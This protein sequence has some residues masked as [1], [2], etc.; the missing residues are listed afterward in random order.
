MSLLNHFLM[1]IPSGFEWV[2]LV[3]VIVI[4]FFGIKKIPELAKSFGRATAEYEKAR[5]QAKRELQQ[6]KSSENEKVGREKLEEIADTLNIDYTNKNDEELRK[7]I[8]SAV[9]KEKGA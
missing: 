7:A 3:V 5:I 2:I 1:Q 4:V 6:I 8:E 9:N